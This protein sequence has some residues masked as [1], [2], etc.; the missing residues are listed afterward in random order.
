M[1]PEERRNNPAIREAVKKVLDEKAEALIAAEKL[2]DEA[3]AILVGVYHGDVDDELYSRVTDAVSRAAIQ[4]HSD[5][6]FIISRTETYIGNLAAFD[7]GR[8][9]EEELAGE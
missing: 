6:R 5:K 8:I 7:L 4:I 9:L 1:S 2:I 3:R